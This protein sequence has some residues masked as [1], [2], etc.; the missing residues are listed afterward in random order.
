LFTG[1]GSRR[2]NGGRR[3]LRGAGRRRGRALCGDGLAV[4][5][6]GDGVDDLGFGEVLGAF[7]LGHVADEHAVAHD[8]GLQ[9][10]CAV[11]VPLSFAAAGQRHPHAELAEAPA[12]QM[13]VDATVTKRVGY[14]AGPEFVHAQED[15]EHS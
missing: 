9:A 4:V 5:G 15:S 7:D 12:Q 3:R 13:S 1:S 2:G 10:G 6:A 11:G 8:L 14:P